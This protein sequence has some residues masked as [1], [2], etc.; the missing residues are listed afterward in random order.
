VYSSF[1]K[2]WLGIIALCSVAGAL[3]PAPRA[4]EAPVAKI[5]RWDR[6]RRGANLF[7]AVERV[8]RLRAAR[9]AGITLV[10][11]APNKWLNGRSE[12]QRGDFLLGP[13][14]RF[15]GIPPRD[16][17]RLR[18]V[19]D[20]AHA[21][22]LDVVLTMLSLPG[23]RWAQH[24]D[25]VEERRI[26]TDARVQDDA[27]RFWVDLASALRGHP[28]VA[29]YNI[30]NEPSPER[31]AVRLADWY[32]GDYA[33]W[34]ARVRGTPADLNLFYRRV[35]AGI[36]RVDPDTPIVLDAGFHATPWAFEVLEPVPDDKVI[37]SF[38]MYEPYAFT[39]AR[40]G[41]RYRYPGVVPVGETAAAGG[42]VRW[43][44]ARL[45]W[46]L[47]PVAEWQRRHRVPS[48]RVFAGEIGVVRTNPGATEYLR[49]LIDAIEG[50]RWHWAFYAFREDEW[51]AMDYELGT[52]RVPWAWW[53]AQQ[54]GVAPDPA[55]VYRPNAL[56]H[57]LRNAVQDR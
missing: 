50:H 52:A 6:V 29:G 54:R 4:A 12:Q 53:Q 11:L 8:E 15:D 14:D 32:T 38:H 51:P 41:G 25:G 21:A 44:R 19:L 24:N 42:G 36:R 34:Y 23:S 16:L 47:Q 27:I 22:G 13:R 48:S 10:R 55:E 26:W 17:A 56:W 18:E 46:F 3:L 43:D 49:D 2:T 40:N 30:R 1:V 39:N 37:Y 9:A 5:A 7:N 20:D 35:V 31:A 28:A 45:E 33:A 57:M